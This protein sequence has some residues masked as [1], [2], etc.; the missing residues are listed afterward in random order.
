MSQ[1]I[2]A[3]KEAERLQAVLTSELSHRVK[4]AF[5]TVIAMLDRPWIR[6]EQVETR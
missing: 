5:S 2:T 6:R 3:R 4:N 1:D